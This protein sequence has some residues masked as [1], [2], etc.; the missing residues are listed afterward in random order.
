MS[1]V[2]V[3]REVYAICFES[4]DHIDAAAEFSRPSVVS[5]RG[6]LPAAESC[7]H[8]VLRPPWCKSNPSRAPS[9]DHAAWRLPCMTGPMR[10]GGPPSR[11]ATMV[12]SSPAP[13]RVK[14]TPV[15]SL[16]QR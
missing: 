12:R 6:V 15:P 10:R 3:R 11:D 9:G 7:T 14:T 2:P 1:R 8:T 5:W 16:S 13:D 4:G